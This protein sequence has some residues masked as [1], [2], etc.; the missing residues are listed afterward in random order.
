MVCGFFILYSFG[1]IT[2]DSKFRL[3]VWSRQIPCLVKLS[4]RGFSARDTVEK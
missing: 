2:G 3:I 1:F 4:K